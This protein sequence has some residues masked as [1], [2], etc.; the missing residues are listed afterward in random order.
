MASMSRVTFLMVRWSR[1][2][3]SS[4]IPMAVGRRH[5]VHRRERKRTTPWICEDCQ[6]FIASSGPMFIS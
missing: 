2:L 1:R 4:S 5:A 3:V 6:G